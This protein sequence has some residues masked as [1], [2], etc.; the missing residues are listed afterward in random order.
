M[1]K[2]GSLDIE[3]VEVNPVSDETRLTLPAL[4]C[5]QN[6]K[7]FYSFTMTA[8]QLAGIA[9]VSSREKGDGYQRLLDRKRADAIKRYIEVGN[10]LP[11][12]VIINFDDPSNVSYDENTR[13]LEISNTPR[14][15][16]V[17]DG[18]HRLF[19]A[20]L[21]SQFLFTQEIADTYQF[22]VSAFV[23][24]SKVQ[25]AK[26]FIDINSYQQGVNKSLLYDLMEMFDD[27]QDLQVDLYVVRA[28]DIVK[29]LNKNPES[30]FHQ[31]ISMTRDRIRGMVSQVTFVDAL[32]PHLE[33]GGILSHTGPY[34]FSL[35][36]QYRILE[37]Y[38]N[39]VR[40]NLPHLWFNE[41]ALVTKT[42]GFS[43]LMLSLPTVFE[44]TV[45]RY[46]GFE[47]PNVETVLSPLQV[48]P[49]TGRE[50]AGQQGTV[51]ARKLAEA[52]K[53]A[54]VNNLNSADTDERIQLAI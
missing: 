25:Q 48:I 19:G 36:E 32:L 15:A 5:H 53:S 39:A 17:I 42:T 54:V 41:E 24:L 4:K 51:A 23:G 22:T 7:F 11:N 34:N 46:K 33:R 35:E 18:Q 28:S 37:N 26:I 40:A 43:A 38:F 47:L 8:T 12:N 29:R 20:A 10:V 14:S 44:Q 9:Y 27:D 1:D 50:L 13:T 30:P 6:G 49:W 2:N 3:I 45:R 31:R 16:W 52:I 21:L